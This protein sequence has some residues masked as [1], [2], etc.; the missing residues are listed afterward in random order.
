MNDVLLLGWASRDVT[1]E[2]P[3]NL[4]G[5]FVMRITGTVRDPLTVTALAM[6]AGEGAAQ[7]LIWVSC[8]TVGI[9][10]AVLELSRRKL[11]ELV[12]EFPVKNLI[13][14]ATHTHT[15]PDTAGEWYPP[16]PEGVLTPGE[17]VEFLTDRIA[18][19]AAE[20]W[21]NRK[22][23]YIAW[24]MAYT[25]IGHGRR[26]TYFDDL[27]KRPG[28]E[29]MPGTRTEKTAS[30]YGTTRDEKFDCIEGYVDHSAHFLFTFDGSRQLTGAV[31]NIAC[32]AQETEQ[33]KETSADFWED[34]R[35]AL[36]KQYGASLFLLPQTS[37]AG[38]LSPRP[39]VNRKARQRMLD[40]KGMSSRE[41]IARLIK[42]AFDETLGWAS[43]EMKDRPVFKHASKIIQLPRRMV[44]EEEYLSIGRGL[45]ELE[46][47]P[48]SKAPD[49]NVRAIEDGVVFARKQRCRRVLRRY[50]EQ[51]RIRTCDMELHVVRIDD[52][53]LATNSFELFGDYGIRIQ[54]R[55]PAMQTFVV[56]L[57][58]GGPASYL[59]TRQAEAGEGYSACVYCND[60]GSDGGD[61]LVNETLRLIAEMWPSAKQS[62]AA[63]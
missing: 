48:A 3:V 42:V 36:R 31:I 17:Y 24:G 51:E 15:A 14:N 2:K 18:Q 38:G 60:V 10:A 50:E 49:A 32:T 47:A 33:L 55:S 13:L 1:A 22:P 29:E 52:I 56:Q 12:K 16:V 58:G 26:T 8:D 5:Q 41:E 57:C 37:A 43:K 19:A 23:G 59:P 46:R 28:F 61:L 7:S 30:M 53:A 34:A 4:A 44:T 20:S 63:Q 54:A 62:P 11:G 39:M 45:A 25:P 40:M 27:S 35:K 9:P 6:S 21:Q